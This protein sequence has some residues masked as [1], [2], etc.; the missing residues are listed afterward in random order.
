MAGSKCNYLEDKII[1]H[2][3]RNTA[4]TSPVSVWLALF[5]TAPDEANGGV[6]ITTNGCVRKQVTFGAP[7]NGASTNSAQVDFPSA[8][9]AGYTVNG[10]V[11]FDAETNGNKLYYE[12]T[13]S[14]PLVVAIGNNVKYA[15]GQLSITES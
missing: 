7:S 10:W 5:S 6:E 9:P 2:V 11:L 1:N 13:S 4:L 3:L 14:S 8:S 15:I 12:D